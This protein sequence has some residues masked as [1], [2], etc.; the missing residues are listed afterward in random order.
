MQLG[1]E[2]IL[3]CL[4]GALERN[5]S[6][7]IVNLW[8]RVLGIV[9]EIVDYCDEENWLVVNFCEFIFVHN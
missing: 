6:Y 5:Y 1:C 7:G 9:G 2:M 8:P 4:C 3:V